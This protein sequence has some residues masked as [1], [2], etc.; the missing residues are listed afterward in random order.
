MS[1]IDPGI[2][3]RGR[4]RNRQGRKSRANQQRG[5]PD[6]GTRRRPGESFGGP[7]WTIS[8]PEA[9]KRYFNLSKNASYEAAKRGEIITIEVGR[10]LRV[11]VKAMERKL[12]DVT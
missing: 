7:E 2:T 1:T 11:P 4:G 9:G 12:E 8:V 5:P 6:P 3:G 10:L